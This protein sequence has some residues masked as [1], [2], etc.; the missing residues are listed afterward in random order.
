[1]KPVAVIELK[2]HLRQKIHD[3]DGAQQPS[4]PIVSHL[5]FIL[6]KITEHESAGRA[7]A[8]ALSALTARDLG[9]LIDSVELTSDAELGKYLARKAV[10]FTD[11]RGQ[12]RVYV[13]KPMRSLTLGRSDP[14]LEI[15]VLCANTTDLAR[16]LMAEPW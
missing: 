15:F 10:G 7:N 14:A 13:E 12:V 16:M 8:A 4:N 6:T 3:L 11:S 9:F 2:D 1:M 5:K